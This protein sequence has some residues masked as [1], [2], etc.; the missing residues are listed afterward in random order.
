MPLQRQYLH[1]VVLSIKYNQSDRTLQLIE[2][3]AINP[4][5][6]TGETVPEEKDK[7]GMRGQC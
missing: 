5:T 7:N 1:T 3:N 2:L 4:K 6:P